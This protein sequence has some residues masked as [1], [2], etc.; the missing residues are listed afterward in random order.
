MLGDTAQFSERVIGLFPKSKLPFD[1]LNHASQSGKVAIVQAKPTSQFPDTLDRV[2]IRA[3]RW[4]VAHQELGFLLCPPSR[5]EL[6]V[7]ILGVV[8]NHHYPATGPAAALPQLAKKVLAAGAGGGI[9]G[10]A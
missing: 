5:V 2:Q 6:G 4:Q 3:I 1:R 10:A 7:V 8:D 9:I